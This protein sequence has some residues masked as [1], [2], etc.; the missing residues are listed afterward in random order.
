M[1]GGKHNIYKPSRGQ[2]RQKT[3]RRSAFL[4]IPQKQLGISQNLLIK[5]Q[6][7]TAKISYQSE[8]KDITYNI[9]LFIKI[10]QRFVSKNIKKIK[11]NIGVFFWVSSVSFSSKL[12]KP[13]LRIKNMSGL[14][15]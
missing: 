10:I 11:I 8:N 5:S 9:V 2:N 4:L 6:N 13:A 1:S 12:M 3:V 14:S 15:H 7:K